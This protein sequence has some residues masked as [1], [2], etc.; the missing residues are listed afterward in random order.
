MY[1]SP[2]LLLLSTLLSNYKLH[3]VRL[4]C[5]PPLS[6][7]RSAGGVWE[8]AAKRSQEERAVYRRI[9]VDLSLKSTKS[10][11]SHRLPEAKETAQKTRLTSLWCCYIFSLP[12]RKKKPFY[13]FEPLNGPQLQHPP[14]TS[15]FRRAVGI[16]FLIFSQRDRRSA[17]SSSSPT[18]FSSSS[19]HDA[20]PNV[21]EAVITS[22]MLWKTRERSQK[23][24]SDQQD[25]RQS[26]LA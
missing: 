1:V 6:V 2:L 24:L 15:L 19:P 12:E 21:T 17:S 20:Q 23:N 10:S 7:C 14:P 13:L 18:H 9:G 16:V 5:P 3:I 11:S 25:R 8:R 26:S 4:S 22:G